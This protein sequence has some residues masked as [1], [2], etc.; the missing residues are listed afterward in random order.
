MPP[1]GW[2]NSLLEGIP[3]VGFTDGSEIVRLSDG[4]L[5]PQP[6]APR[7]PLKLKE[8]ISDQ[9]NAI[10]LNPRQLAFSSVRPPAN[11]APREHLIFL[12]CRPVTIDDL[13]YP[14]SIPQTGKRQ[15]ERSL[16]RA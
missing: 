1:S 14:K 6:P 15:A 11:P 3:D 8:L 10:W 12:E 7:K 16:S 4:I 13:T 2:P 9:I 5:E